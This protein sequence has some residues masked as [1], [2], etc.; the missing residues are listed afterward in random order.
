MGSQVTRESTVSKSVL[1][2]TSSAVVVVFCVIFCGV[3]GAEDDGSKSFG[4]P[5]SS[6]GFP[7]FQQVPLQ[8][9]S[10]S[11]PAWQPPLPQ[12]GFQQQPPPQQQQAYQAPASPYGYGPYGSPYGG[13]MGM[14]GMGNPMQMLQ[15]QMESQ[16][17]L[18]M[19][20]MMNQRPMM[21]SGMNLPMVYMMMN[22]FKPQEENGDS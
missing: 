6:A 16:M 11:V 17:M 19:L 12:Q 4:Q 9:Q 21:G 20:M 10:Q 13:G 14:G 3:Q 5:S 15:G 7:P 22:G 8:Q 18:P 2:M 1:A